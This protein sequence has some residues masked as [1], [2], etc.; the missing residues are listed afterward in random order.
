VKDKHREVAKAALRSAGLAGLVLVPKEGTPELLGN[1]VLRAPAPL[2]PEVP[3]Y[4][5]PD[6]FAQANAEGTAGLVGEAV[7]LLGAR[8]TDRA[9]EL[10]CG[11]GNFTFALAKRCAQVVAVES[12][13]V[14]LELAR[15][16]AREAHLSNVRFIEGDSRKMT[17]GLIAEGQRFDVL[18]ADPPRAGARGIGGW[19]RKLGVRTVVYVACDP[20]SLSRDAAELSASGYGPRT[21]RVVDMFPQ[22]RHV[23]AVMS[24]TRAEGA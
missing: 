20:A 22:T 9:L 3:L 21:L 14:S 11:N 18:L 16:S 1:P 15:R 6:A 2:A 8:P 7:A 4:G 17:E 12:G 5:R 24:F 23:E 13:R 19:A 10:Y